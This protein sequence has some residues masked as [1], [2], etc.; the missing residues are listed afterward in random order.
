M[1]ISTPLA[2]LFTSMFLFVGPG[3]AQADDTTDAQAADSARFD[4]TEL[5]TEGPG[6]N[7]TFQELIDRGAVVVGSSQGQPI[8]GTAIDVNN[9]LLESNLDGVS[10]TVRPTSIHTHVR[11]GIRAG[12]FA[13]WS[14]WYQEDGNTQIFR[15]FEGEQSVRSTNNIKAGR[16]EAVRTYPVPEAG[17]WIQWQATYTIVRPGNGCIFQLMSEADP[18]TGQGGLWALH[19]NQ[20]P[21][22]NIVLQ[23]RRASNGQARTELIAQDVVGK[24][25]SVRVCYDG[26]TQYE[27]YRKIHGEDADFVFVG[28]G[29]YHRNAAE[30]VGFRW[31]IYQGSRPGS[32]IQQDCLLLVTGV[33]VSTLER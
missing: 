22:G 24:N 14:R 19:L 25:V 3:H 33:N 18:D 6:E 13:Q 26:R 1:R 29:T 9:E 28:A 7:P 2:A 31:G 32:S 12:D 17:R 21:E 10:R 30:T 15:L 20:T 27:V 8:A 5:Y 11:S 16:I 4:L 23:R